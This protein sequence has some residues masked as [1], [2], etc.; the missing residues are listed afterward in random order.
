MKCSFSKSDTK[1]K[2]LLVS[3]PLLVLAGIVWH[4]QQ[5]PAYLIGTWKVGTP[6][7]SWQ[8][9]ERKDEDWAIETTFRPNG[10][11]ERV[12]P[13]SAGA[14]FLVFKGRYSA[15]GS[16]FRLFGHKRFFRAQRVDK[17]NDTPFVPPSDSIMSN[18]VL[19]EIYNAD[20]EIAAKGETHYV[21]SFDEVTRKM[22]TQDEMEFGGTK[23]R[24]EHRT[25]IKQP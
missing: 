6:L 2:L 3:L 13:D 22:V 17:D 11:W 24:I 20:Q 14:G 12:F 7:E 25:W 8:I 16:K 19:W 5:R 21:I 10:T 15:F 1:R 4:S 18:F 9:K 23:P